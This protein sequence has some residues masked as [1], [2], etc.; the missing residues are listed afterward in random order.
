MPKPESSCLGPYVGV[1]GVSG[2]GFKVE[3]VSGLRRLLGLGGE[4][5]GS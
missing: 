5:A 3:S 2:L 1:Q 4:Q